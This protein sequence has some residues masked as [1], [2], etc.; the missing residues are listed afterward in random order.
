MTGLGNTRKVSKKVTIVSSRS[1]SPGSGVPPALRSA[2][3]QNAVP[4]AVSTTTRT[5]L[6]FSQACRRAVMASSISRFRA[7]MA[8]GRVKVIQPTW[9]LI[10]KETDSLIS[11]PQSRCN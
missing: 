1:F 11:N 6:S 5:W 10:S 2:P 8:F 9:P 3:A 4:V 7:F